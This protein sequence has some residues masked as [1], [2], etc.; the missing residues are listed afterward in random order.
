MSFCKRDADQEEPDSISDLDYFCWLGG[1]ALMMVAMGVMAIHMAM[2]SLWLTVQWWPNLLAVTA[3]ASV[4][5][6]PLWGGLSFLAWGWIMDRAL[7]GMTRKSGSG[8]LFL[9][10]PALA[11]VPA[12]ALGLLS[13]WW[14]RDVMVA[15][16]L[17]VYCTA[18]VVLLLVLPPTGIHWRGKEKTS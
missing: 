11:A 16:P 8:I 10:S 18:L 12:Q 2:F 3:L 13:W 6:L 9:I 7:M 5:G 15:D 17:I 1:S 14:G 4:V